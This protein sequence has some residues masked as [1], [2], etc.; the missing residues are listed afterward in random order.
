MEVFCKVDQ[1]IMPTQV[2]LLAQLNQLPVFQ[3]NTLPMSPP[4]CLWGI[5]RAH[6]NNLKAEDKIQKMKD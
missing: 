4:M 6:M 5:R 2:N 3:A 1:R